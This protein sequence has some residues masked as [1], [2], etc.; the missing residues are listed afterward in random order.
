MIYRKYGSTDIEVSA[1]GF[2]G[3]RFADQRDTDACAS[4]VETAYDKGINYFDT[5]TAYGKS[6]ELF[7]IAFKQMLKTRDQKPFYVSTKT[8]KSDPAL[9]RKDIETSLKR[10]NLDYIDF[11]HVWCVLSQ[12]DYEK[13]KAAG[14]LAEFE[15]LKAEGLI[16]HICFSTHATSPEIEN[17]LADYPFDGTLM[18]Y[19]VMDFPYRDAGLTAASKLNRAVVIMNPL[20]GGIIPQ[21]PDLFN[22]VKTR[23]NETVPQAALRFLLNDPRITTAL[24]GFSNQSDLSEAVSAV[25]GFEAITKEKIKEIR[26]QLQN[27]FT[28]L[29]TSC[30]YCAKCPNDIDV[31]KFMDAYNLF[32]LNN[33]DT[34]KMLS[35]LSFHWDINAKNHPLENCTLCGRCELACTQKLPITK[36]LEFIR[37]ELEKSL[38]NL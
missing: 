11:Y 10:M 31:P 16:K 37:D 18:G 27:A 36:R 26:N 8:F 25:D 7:G 3:M 1:I 29:C 32:L 19:S 17:I 4:L 34:A 12:E 35:R 33:N 5:A 9:I 38:N 2:G 21:N 23:P 20:A 22:F 28:E 6:E 14:V 15:K 30:R 13:R 24:V